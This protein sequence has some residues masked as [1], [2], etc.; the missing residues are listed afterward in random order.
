MDSFFP[1]D[2]EHLSY[3]RIDIEDDSPFTL[4]PAFNAMTPKLTILI[5]TDIST[6]YIK[7]REHHR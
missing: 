3:A 6:N 2:Y 5:C 4:I 7:Y 1:P